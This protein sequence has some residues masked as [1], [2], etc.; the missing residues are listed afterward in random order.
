MARTS[1]KWPFLQWFMDSK[2]RGIPL[3]SGAPTNKINELAESLAT[4][5]IVFGDGF[6]TLLLPAAHCPRY[7]KPWDS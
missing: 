7:N 3:P 6:P 4:L 5:A 1:V 2:R